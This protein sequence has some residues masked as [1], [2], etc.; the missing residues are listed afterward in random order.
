MKFVV[1]RRGSKLVHYNF[2]FNVRLRKIHREQERLFDY[3]KTKN[4]KKRT[5]KT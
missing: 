3:K 4:K 2:S 1:F 5:K